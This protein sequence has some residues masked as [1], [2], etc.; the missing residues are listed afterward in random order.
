MSD[1]YFKLVIIS[2]IGGAMLVVSIRNIK[3]NKARDRAYQAY[4]KA[5]RIL[6]T[7]FKD[8]LDLADKTRN[9]MGSGNVSKD[10]FRTRAW[11]ILLTEPCLAQMD[12]E[13]SNDLRQVYNLIEEAETC[14]S[15]L[16]ETSNQ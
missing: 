12:E 16:V 5:V 10:R 14:R 7:E 9:Q 11:G 15:Q 13:A 4:R 2:L 1:E 6:R 3:C 8:N